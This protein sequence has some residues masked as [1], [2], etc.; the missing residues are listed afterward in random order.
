MKKRVLRTIAI[1]IVVGAVLGGA[2]FGAIMWQVHQSVQEN[3]RI[4]QQAHPNPGDDVAALIDFMNSESHSLRD[5]NH[6]A[7][8][9]LGRLRALRALAALESVYTGD[10]CDHDRTLCQ[11]ELAKAIKRCSGIPNPPQRARH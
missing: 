10:P 4:A 3:C 11:Y 8:W 5:R 1:V 6:R 2:A 9:T 7:V